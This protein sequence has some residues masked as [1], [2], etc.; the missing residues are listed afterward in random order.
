VNWLSKPS[1]AMKKFVPISV[2]VGLPLPSFATNCQRVW[3]TDPAEPEDMFHGESLPVALKDNNLPAK[4]FG[5][6]MFTGMLRLLQANGT[7][8]RFSARIRKVAS[9]LEDLT[10]IPLVKHQLVSIK[11]VQPDTYTQRLCCINPLRD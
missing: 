4:R 3:V 9:D 2:R 10:N 7:F 11:E 1:L 6:L 5:L 8:A